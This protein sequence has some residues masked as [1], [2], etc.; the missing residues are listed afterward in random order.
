[1]VATAYTSMREMKLTFFRSLA[2]WRV[3]SRTLYAMANSLWSN[4]WLQRLL[5]CLLKQEVMEW[6]DGMLHSFSMQVYV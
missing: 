3:T 4:S 1:M 6:S 2:E 5:A